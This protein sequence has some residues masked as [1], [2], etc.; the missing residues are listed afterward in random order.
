MIQ[1]SR[2]R[3]TQCQQETSICLRDSR[4]W[5][6]LRQ[7]DAPGSMISPFSG[8]SC[9]QSHSWEHRLHFG[10]LTFSLSRPRL[11]L[12]AIHVSVLSPLRFSKDDHPYLN[13]AYT[14]PVPEAGDTTY[15]RILQVLR[16]FS[17]H[18]Y[19]VKSAEYGQSSK[20][21]WEKKCIF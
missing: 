4:K 17:S 15:P 9:F 7:P 20:S 13:P 6:V 8:Q 11:F 12:S 19:S 3:M 5:V 1:Q 10:H 21:L 2:E 14:C 16:I 18:N